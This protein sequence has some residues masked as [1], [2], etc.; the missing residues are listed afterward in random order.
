MS[1]LENFEGTRLVMRITDQSKSRSQ[2]DTN[3]IAYYVHKVYRFFHTQTKN[4]VQGTIFSRSL[5]PWTNL[6]HSD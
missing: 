5:F 3:I 2:W 1:G 4:L 6:F